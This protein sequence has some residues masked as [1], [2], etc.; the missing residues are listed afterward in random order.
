MHWE[1]VYY[2]GKRPDINILSE[3]ESKVYVLYNTFQLWEASVESDPCT[4]GSGY[5]LC[6]VYV[7]MFLIITHVTDNIICGGIT[8]CFWY[9]LNKVDHQQN[10]GYCQY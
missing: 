7:Y 1:I 10:N 5:E 2:S 4:E 9:V 8:K 3:K 6:L